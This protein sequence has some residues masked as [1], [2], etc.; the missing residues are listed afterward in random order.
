MSEDLFLETLLPTTHDLGG[1]KVH[2]TL[3]HKARTAIGPFTLEG[4]LTLPALE[5][6][7]RQGNWH[8]HIHALSAA[9]NG[10]PRLII[11]DAAAKALANGM[12]PTRQGVCE[13]IGTFA[14]GETVAILDR[15]GDLL[16]MA[17]PLFSSTAL[18]TVP[19]DTP[20]LN[21]RRV[22]M[23]GWRSS[24]ALDETL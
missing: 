6:A 5:E 14:A 23:A 18:D 21:L 8:R 9:V 4:A 13:L 15:N 16:A 22:L 2:R 10:F 12:A 11:T 17:S 3:P 7:V 19:A 1:F 24:N 20:V